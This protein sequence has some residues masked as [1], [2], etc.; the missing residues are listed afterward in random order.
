MIIKNVLKSFILITTCSI[1]TILFFPD[2]I[3][4]HRKDFYLLVGISL[5]MSYCVFFKKIQLSILKSVGFFVSLFFVTLFLMGRESP[6]ILLVF[7]PLC[8]YIMGL[9]IISK[10]IDFLLNK[11]NLNNK[12]LIFLTVLMFFIMITSIVITKREIDIQINWREVKK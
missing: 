2:L 11:I 3:F 6:A 1:F 12:F 9:W 10:I 4:T 5:V 7:I 8:G